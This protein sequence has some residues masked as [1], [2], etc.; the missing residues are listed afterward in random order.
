[1]IMSSAPDLTRLESARRL[2]LLN[3]KVIQSLFALSYF[4]EP[5]ELTRLGCPDMI[6]SIHNWSSTAMKHPR[7]ALD[8]SKKKLF[9]IICKD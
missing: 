8:A 6:E 1:M 7:L 2:L 3:L 9:A 4:S 5:I